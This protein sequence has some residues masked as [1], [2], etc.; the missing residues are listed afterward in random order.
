MPVRLNG[1]TS[2]YVELASP[3][4]GG[5]TVLELPTDS[6]KPGMVLINTTTFSAAAS[7]SINNC[8]SATYE[9]YQIVVSKFVGTGNG[10]FK[11]RMRSAGTDASGSNYTFQLFTA[12]GTTPDYARYSSQTAG[13]IASI[14]T[15]A[16]GSDVSLN[17]FRPFVTSPTNMTTGVGYDSYSGAM[18]SNFVSS[19][20]LSTS[21]DGFTLYP[22]TGTMTGTVRIYGYRNSL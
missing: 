18:I 10:D 12:N 17:I 4:V 20:S 22:S 7:V 14:R 8:F 21:Y 9:N 15:D 6:I 16:N 3:A 19:H 5:S 13:Q 2:G 1:S 11:I